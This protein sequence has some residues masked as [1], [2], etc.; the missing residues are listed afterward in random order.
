MPANAVK[1]KRDERLWG[2]AKS[3]AAKQGKKKD[4]AYVMGTYQ[5]MK[6]RK[7]GKK[8]AAFEAGMFRALIAGGLPEKVAIA[9]CASHES[10]KRS[11]RSLTKKSK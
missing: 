5:R 10:P 8:E 2:E 1:T 6:G 7:G 11:E 4:W 9:A 3:Q